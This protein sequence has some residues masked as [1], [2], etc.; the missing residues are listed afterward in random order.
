MADRNIPEFFQRLVADKCISETD[1]LNTSDGFFMV[2]KSVS[3]ILEGR[4]ILDFLDSED[5]WLDCDKFF[6]DWFLYAV[7]YE[8]DYIYSLVKLREQEHDAEQGLIADGDTPGVTVS[9]ISLE[10]EILYD[11]LKNSS[12]KNR[13]K[14]NAE[15]NRVVSYRG[16]S[17]HTA[18]KKYFKNP[19]SDAPYLI[20]DVYMKHIAGFSENGCLEVPEYYK[21][22]VK[23]YRLNKKSVKLS[24]LP[25]FIELLNQKAGCVVCDNEKIYI[26]NPDKPTKYESLAIL[27]T[28]TANTS[29]YSFAAEVEYHARFLTALAK[30]KIP[31]YGRSIYDSA[32]RADMSVGDT[33]LQGS[34]PFYKS[35]SRIVKR[36]YKL[37]FKD[38]KWN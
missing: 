18:L 30:I 27:A 37:H 3:D 24:R 10:Q 36:Q 34:A 35:G 4:G 26:K 13:K 17:H 1:I 22:I 15:I 16:Q 38:H 33:E 9:F 29:V 5:V 2:Y 23:Q 31:F 19:Q 8:S 20:A 14:L 32:I 11:C 28:H 25:E 12:D 7:P 21:E 6:D